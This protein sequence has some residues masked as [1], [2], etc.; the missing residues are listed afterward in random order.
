MK[1]DLTSIGYSNIKRVQI[2][3]SVPAKS[4]N[5]KDLPN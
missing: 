5:I 4:L 3:P 1:I 2:P